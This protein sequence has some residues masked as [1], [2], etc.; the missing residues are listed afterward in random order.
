M[1]AVAIALV[2]LVA[3][4]AGANPIIGEWM[5]IDFDP[6][7]FVHRVDPAIYTAVDA[8]VMLDLTASAETGF[9]SVSFTL[10]VTPGMSS[11]P[12]FTNLLPG[13]LA[14]GN[15]ET[16]ITLASTECITVDAGREFIDPVIFATLDLF[17]LGSPGEVLWVDHPEYARWILDCEDPEAEIDFF[18]VWT[19]GGVNQDPAPGDVDCEANTPVEASSWGAIK[20]LYH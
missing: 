4:T 6:P 7:N 9:S 12:S 17:Y 18:C 15:W 11:P 8:Y 2:L 19:N 14:I 13:D 1:R 5:Y 16:G 10:A 20:A 3:G